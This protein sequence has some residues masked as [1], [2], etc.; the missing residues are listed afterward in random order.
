MGRGIAGAATLGGEFFGAA[1]DPSNWIGWGRT[2]LVKAGSQAGMNA[3]LDALAQGADLASGVQDDY[4]ARRTALAAALGGGLSLATDAAGRGLNRLLRQP[5]ANVRVDLEVGDELNA[6]AFSMEDIAPTPPRVDD[7]I[8]PSQQ[9]LDG[10]ISVEAPGQV[11]EDFLPNP[12]RTRPDDSG[13]PTESPSGSAAGSGTRESPRGLPEGKSSGWQ[14][15]DWTARTSPERAEAAVR[16]LDKLKRW[17]KPDQV[18]AFIKALDDG[19]PDNAGASRINERWIDWDRMG[20]PREVLGLTGALADI[21]RSTYENAGGAKQGW[22]TAAEVSKQLGFTLADLI[23]THADITGEGGIAIRAAALRDAALASDKAFYDQLR[24][25]QAAVKAGDLTGVPG[26]VE[27][28][29]R[30]VVLGAMDAGASAEIA[31]ALQYRQR[32][33]DFIRGDLQGALTQLSE[34]LNRG[35]ELDP[36]G[37]AAMLS[38]LTEAYESGGSAGLRQSIAKM[39]EMGLWDYVGYYATANLLSAP[40]THIRNALG[41]PLH[42]LF[43]IGERYVAAGIGAARTAAGLGSKERVTFREAAAYASGLTQ[44]WSEALVLARDAFVRGAPVADLRSSVMSAEMA[45]N[46]PFAFSRQRAA[47]WAQ[48][49]LS[50][51]TWADMLG[52]VSFEVVRTLGFRPSVAVDELYKALGRRMQLNALAYREAAYRAALVKPE[53][54]DAVFARTLAAMQEQPTA[55]AFREAKAFFDARAGSDPAD[56]QV[57]GS[58]DED[59]ALILRSIDHR[60]MAADHARLLTFQT[61]GPIVDKFDAAL[62]AVPLVKSLWVNFVR[63]PVAL[64]KAGLV[65]RNPVIGGVAAGLELTTRSGREKHKALFDALTS[66]E[67]ALARGGAEAD[68][69][70]ARQAVGAAVLATIWMFWASGN[71]TGKQTQEQRRSAVEDYSFR[72]P[73][74]TW[75]Q[76]T[77]MSPLGEMLGLVADTASAIRDHDLDD[78]GLTAI[79]GALAAAVRNNVVNKSFLSGL[80]DFMEMM[81]GGGYRSAS[82]EASGRTIASQLA[83]AAAPRIV[84]GGA[85]L[86]RIAQE[87]DPVIRDVRSFRD[88]VLAGVPTVSESLAARRDFLGRPLVRPEGKR[89]VFQAFNTSR[90]TEDPLER[91]L[92]HLAVTLGDTF[93]IGMPPRKMNGGDLTPEEYSR[94][95]EVQG[96]LYRRQGLNM[97]ETLRDLIG[98]PEYLEDFPEGRAYRIKRVIERFREGANREVRRPSSPL[99]MREAARRTGADRLRTERR[100]RGWSEDY[101]LSRALDYGLDPSDPDIDAL[102]R[103]LSDEGL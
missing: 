36:A 87:E 90:P 89:G 46:V 85:L 8:P 21:F 84:P 34:V 77:G 14:S 12:Y 81:T 76:Y 29:N 93:R 37:L 41:T 32:Q 64:L 7:S 66:E 102:H 6:P 101:A 5:E 44:S 56:I 39:R 92:A 38:K 65:A 42:A 94:L 69:V 82:D 9:A 96:Q 51:R 59:M 67:N 17:I 74:G 35:Q 54:A 22:D 15:V 30:T 4:D 23:K 52:V 49:P 100:R 60:A 86:R 40:T 103:A 91:E 58:V 48:K 19:L 70:L 55:A 98:R 18:D 68:L 61:S 47:G 53:E 10:G 27:A 25:V 57:P 62:R 24:T 95:L 71:I 16:H 3:G 26:M 50:P 2:L 97:E 31:R 33:P 73:D 83:Q 28:L 75:V 79:M 63:T 80:G 1:L 43:Q 99:F 72:L 20:D 88:M 11:G 13:K 45:A 78:D